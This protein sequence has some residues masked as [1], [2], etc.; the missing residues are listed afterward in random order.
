MPAK[1][2]VPSVKRS[3]PVLSRREVDDIKAQI[4]AD[5]ADLGQLTNTPEDDVHGVHLPVGEVLEVGTGSRESRIRRNE[6]A[7][8]AMDPANLRLTGAQRQES[9][10]KYFKLKEQLQ[11]KMLTKEEM[12]YFPSANDSVKQA[13]YEKAVRKATTPGFE[14]SAEYNVLAQE[15]KRLGRLLWPEDPTM[16]S[17]TEIR[18]SGGTSGRHFAKR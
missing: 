11:G 8:A 3:L 7:L 14:S 6:K 1:I 16:C 18:P 5:K 10:K 13:N 12:D 4:A 15:F 9:E 2:A 17:L